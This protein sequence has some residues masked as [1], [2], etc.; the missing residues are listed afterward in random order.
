MYQAVVI[1][2][3]PVIVDGLQ[4][5]ID[6]SG[7]HIDI[8]CAST[9]PL[10]A[11]DYILSHPVHIVLTDVAMPRMNGLELIRRIKEEKP[12]IYVIVL[13]AYNNFEYVRTALKLGAENYLLK[14]LDPGELL[15]TLSQITAHLKEREQLN[16]T[17]GR[18]MLTFR[19]AFTEQWLKDLL[20]GTEFATKADLLGID[21][22]VSS[23]TVTI[24][25]S[26]TKDASL[27]SGFFD[28]LLRYLPGRYTGN[29]YFE[30]PY[31]LIGVLSPAASSENRIEIFIDRVLKAAAASDCP[32]FASV[33]PT[34]TSYTKVHASYLRADEMAFL[35]YTSLPCFFCTPDGIHA[36]E[37]RKALEGYDAAQPGDIRGIAA[38]Y[39]KYD[40][41]L[42][43]LHL[44]SVQIG[45]LC[46]REYEL[47][48]TYPDL[49]PLLAS[50]PP[51]LEKSTDADTCLSYLRDFLCVSAALIQK[52]KKATYPVVDAVIRAVH[53]FTDKDISLKTLAASM[54]VSPAYLGT[55]FHQQTGAYFNDYLTEA[56]LQYAAKLLEHSNL[57]I[58]DIV[59]KTG[60]SSQTY[61]NRSFKRY[62]DISPMSFRRVKAGRV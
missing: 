41:H 3:E 30:T 49:L 1:D 50:C 31:R 6:W 58:K 2:D 45:T 19:S 39:E 28:L 29:F 62:F 34:V 9:D 47:G 32:V 53:E 26:P 4:S 48:E 55:I 61:F 59:D 7:F 46:K 13:S 21:L 23:F 56:R 37:L 54:H 11:L 27:M 12:S 51:L 44:L 60:F 25:S 10:A 16:A 36:S 8:A 35:E 14:P 5:A 43:T 18:T 40:P 15:D 20:S 38:L 42:V 17:Y 57:R 24:F 22:S 33:G 52:T